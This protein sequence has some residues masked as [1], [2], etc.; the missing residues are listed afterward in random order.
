MKRPNIHNKYMMTAFG[1]LLAALC[2]IY[3]YFFSS[4]SVDSDT[5]YIYI[6]NVY[7]NLQTDKTKTE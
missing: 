4:M 5:H 7:L 1:C 2:I 3:Y 6:D